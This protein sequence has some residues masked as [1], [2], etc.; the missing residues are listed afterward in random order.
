MKNPNDKI[1]ISISIA[2][3]AF[4]LA[5]VTGISS[6]QESSI[7]PQGQDLLKGATQEIQEIPETMQEIATKS[8]NQ[9]GDVG[10]EVPEVIDKIIEESENTSD[11]IE[12][13]TNVVKDSLPDVPVV[14]KQKDG[15]LLEL[16]S[17][18]EDTGFPGCEEKNV[19]FIPE[20]AVMAKGGEAIWTNNDNVAHTVT[21]G[22]PR[23][24]PDGLFNSG[25]I[26][27]GDTYSLQFD[28][29]FEYDYFCLVHP[30]MS[31]TVVIE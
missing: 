22:N 21:S 23:D 24:G 12:K 7:Q 11:I 9:V 8:L 6:V 5:L 28:I 3:T 15:K 1:G 2:V 16:I 14:I 26:I 25:L 29:A 4:A 13:S 19:C 20:K 30:W 18:P 10:T 31:G 27:P 17:I